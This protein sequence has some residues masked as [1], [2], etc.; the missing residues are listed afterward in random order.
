MEM[1]TVMPHPFSPNALFLTSSLLHP[2]LKL[3]LTFPLLFPH[4]KPY[5]F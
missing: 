1:E 4:P 3:S 5:S 2:D